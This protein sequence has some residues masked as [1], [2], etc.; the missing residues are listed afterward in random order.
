M[1][2]LEKAFNTKDNEKFELAEKAYSVLYEHLQQREHSEVV[3]GAN[4][5]KFKKERYYS[6]I[7][8]A[9]GFKFSAVYSNIYEFCL[10]E[11]GLKKRSVANRIAVAKQFADLNG[12][13]REDYKPFSFTQL[14]VLLDVDKT[15]KNLFYRFTP[16]MLVKDM[17]M[18][19]KAI[20]KGT[21][22]YLLSNEENIEKINAFLEAEKAGKVEEAQKN[23]ESVEEQYE[24]QDKIT[25]DGEL[26]PKAEEVQLNALLKLEKKE[27]EKR[28]KR[29]FR[30]KEIT[31][32]REEK[33]ATIDSVVQYIIKEIYGE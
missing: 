33:R 5:I 4:L 27:V 31:F 22:D 6:I 28:L 18:L 3:F 29:V 13:L 2:K 10:H 7:K 8:P 25:A 21:F 16:E 19:C 11:F 14:V 15:N 24:K 20:K 23:I 32:Y 17:K 1:R 30:K 26:V 9:S 12:I